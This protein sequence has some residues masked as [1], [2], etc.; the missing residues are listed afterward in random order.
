MGE[1]YAVERVDEAVLDEQCSGHDVEDSA[2]L[3]KN[4]QSGTNSS[5]W[6]VED[7][8]NS[9]LRE[10]GEEEHASED[11]ESKTKRGKQLGGKRLP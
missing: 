10:V 8:Q 1:T 7:G 2:T 11:T 6:S 5:Q 9:G 3:T 4:Q